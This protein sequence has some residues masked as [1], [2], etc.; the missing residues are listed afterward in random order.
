VKIVAV[1]PNPITDDA[2]IEIETAE[3]GRTR[4]SVMDMLGQEVE[5]VYDGELSSG[6]RILPLNTTALT[7]GSYYIQMSTPTVRCTHR[8]SIVK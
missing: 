1:R 2:Q 5:T 7:T 8:I 3:T 4:I 6:Q